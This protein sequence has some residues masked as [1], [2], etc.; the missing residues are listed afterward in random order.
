MEP[1]WTFKAI[2]PKFYPTEDKGELA[3]HSRS[4][5]SLCYL[6]DLIQIVKSVNGPSLTYLFHL[7]WSKYTT[8]QWVCDF[9]TSA[10]FLV[11]FWVRPNFQPKMWPWNSPQLQNEPKLSFW[12]PKTMLPFSGLPSPWWNWHK[13]CVAS[14]RSGTYNVWFVAGPGGANEVGEVSQGMMRTWKD[15]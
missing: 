9:S 5:V 4:G 15:T 3:P 8:A 7:L 14:P 12:P 6:S 13:S 10:N 1:F 2:N 11:P